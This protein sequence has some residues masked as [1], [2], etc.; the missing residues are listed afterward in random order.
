MSTNPD[1][2]AIFLKNTVRLHLR[3]LVSMVFKLCD[4][5]YIKSKEVLVREGK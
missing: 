3:T 2:A 5:E 1:K 4:R